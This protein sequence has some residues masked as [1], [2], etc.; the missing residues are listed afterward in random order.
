[1]RGMLRNEYGVADRS[2]SI[3]PVMRSPIEGAAAG[4]ELAA[5]NFGWELVLMSL[6]ECCSAIEVIVVN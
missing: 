5:Q 2:V 4:G 3:T 6:I 1:M